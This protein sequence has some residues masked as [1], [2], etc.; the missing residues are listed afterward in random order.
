MPPLPGKE[1]DIIFEFK[2]RWSLMK[3]VSET[4]FS[5]TGLPVNNLIDSRPAYARMRTLPAS[6]DRAANIVNYFNALK[7]HLREAGAEEAAS[8]SA[9][10]FHDIIIEGIATAANQPTV[11]AES[12]RLYDDILTSFYVYKEIAKKVSKIII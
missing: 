6:A 10:D 3:E 8:P 4:L 9:K 1:G 12:K 7:D 2:I 11:T 5:T